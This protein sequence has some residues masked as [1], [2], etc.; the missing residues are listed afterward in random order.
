MKKIGIL[1]FHR[2]INYG[3]QL[4]AYALQKTVSDLG[5]ECEL[6]DYICPAITKPYKPIY[7]KKND[8]IFSFAKSLIMFN[9]RI[10]K[11]KSFESFQKKIIK[12]E[13]QYFPETIDEVKDKYDLFITGSDQVFSPWCADFDPAYFLTFADDNQKY[14]YAAS[15]ATKEIPKEFKAEFTNRLQGF[16]KISVREQEGVKFVNELCKKEAEVNL[17]PTILLNAEKWSEVA[18]CDCDEPYVFVYSVMPQISLVNFALKLA[19]E[20]KMKV[21]FVNDAPHLPNSNIEYKRATSVEKFVGYIKNASYVVSN[22]FHA[23]AFSAIF[24]KSM[25]IEFQNKVN[26][27]VRAESFLDSLGISRGVENGVAEE[28]PIDWNDVDKKLSAQREKSLD[29]L[30]KIINTEQF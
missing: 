20:K 27:N 7:I 24:H 8:P 10:K 23:T 2:A 12:S 29:Y 16:Q 30:R 4:Q 26:R 18:E 11:A 6:V 14:S 22:S 15:F 17:D 19:K 28:T 25:F 9:R 13:K 5:A 1:T 21:I 3:A